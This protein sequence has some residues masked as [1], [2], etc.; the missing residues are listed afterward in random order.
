MEVALTYEDLC[1]HPPECFFVAE[2][3][4]PIS[5][6]ELVADWLSQG[7]Q[8]MVEEDV[9]IC[10]KCTVRAGLLLTAYAELSREVAPLRDDKKR[11]DWLDA[12]KYGCWGKEL[13]AGDLAA[14]TQIETGGSAYKGFGLRAAI[15]AANP[16]EIPDSLRRT[17]KGD[18]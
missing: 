18:H 3:A 7:K 9:E 6:L 4:Q 1:K 11:M 8:P 14:R 2:K 16:P 10:H 5:C 13:F 15:D 12:Q 17:R